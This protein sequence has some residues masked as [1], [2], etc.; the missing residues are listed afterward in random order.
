[1]VTWDKAENILCVRL[2][3]IGDVLMTTPAFRALKESKPGRKLTLLTSGSGEA[4]AHLIPEINEVI[5]FDSPWMKATPQR[6]DSGFDVE[7][8]EQLRQEKFDAAVIF[9]VFSQ[10]PLPAAYLCYLAE[11]PLRL[12]YC[13]ENPYQLLNH[14]LKDNETEH[15]LRH[16]VRRQLDLV[17]FV[18]CETTNDRLSLIVP[19]AAIQSTVNLL[20]MQD[21]H[22]NM[23]E[24]WIVIHPG[25][26]AQSRRYPAE[27]Y[28][29]VADILTC[30]HNLQVV[31]TGTKS[32]HQ[33]VEFIRAN[34]RGHTTSL[35]GRINLAEM[36]ALI[37]MAPLL[38]TNNTG[39][40]H[41]AA[42]L[43]TPL[44]Q[45]YALTNP[46]HTPWK[47]TSRVLSHDVPC[48]NCFKSICP[49]EHHHCLRLI[50]PQDVVGEAISLL[51]NP[52]ILG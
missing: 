46:Q 17:R 14:W 6:D 18:G 4:I 9:T 39:P 52:S 37:K 26:T 15:S 41:M 28:I 8:I 29:T 19:E 30:D 51:A 2:D 11:I 36:T 7:M 33:L 43:D 25:A 21:P 27:K 40:A 50:N 49:M 47:G 32:E 23:N 5:R 31:F 38:I 35:V 48:K 1:M 10:N 42:A 3:S 24:P 45:L 34:V 12:G 22:F 44:V 16:E 13:R 20:V